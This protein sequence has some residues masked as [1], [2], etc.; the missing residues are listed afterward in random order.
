M[1]EKT[2]QSRAQ[3]AVSEL[4]KKKAQNVALL[5]DGDEKLGNFLLD[6]LHTTGTNVITPVKYI[7]LGG[8]PFL[9]GKLSD[10][11]KQDMVSWV[12]SV[13]EHLQ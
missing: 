10:A 7:K 11:E 5:I 3:K 12:Q 4:N 6:I 1:T 8:I 2:T 9:G 13:I